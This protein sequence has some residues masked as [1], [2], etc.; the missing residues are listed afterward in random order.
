FIFAVLCE[1]LGFFGGFVVLSLYFVLI[2]RCLVIMQ[3]A[4]DKYGVLVTAGI[5]AMFLFH[6]LENIGMNIGIMPITGIPL[7]FISSGGSSVITN[8]LAI[9]LLENIWI[10]RQKLIF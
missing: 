4:K 8:L 7:P 9:G 6:I 1:E 2:W 3:Q 10:R 5:M